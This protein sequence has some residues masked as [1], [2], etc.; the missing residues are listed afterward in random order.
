[1]IARG[2]GHVL[3]EDGPIDHGSRPDDRVEENDRVS[4]DRATSTTTPGDSTEF[5]TEPFITQPW[6]DQAAMD[7][8]RGPDLG[9]R[10]FLGPGVDDPL[11]VV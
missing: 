8:R 7:L 5:T 6:A 2:N 3:V 9:R 4:D 10:T 11:A 1:M